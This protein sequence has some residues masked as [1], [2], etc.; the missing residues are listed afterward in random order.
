MRTY[1]ARLSELTEASQDVPHIESPVMLTTVIDF[2]C[3][4][5]FPEIP[6]LVDEGFEAQRDSQ[7]SILG[8]LITN[9]PRTAC[10]RVSGTPL[11]Y[12]LDDRTNIRILHCYTGAA[13]RCLRF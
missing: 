9:S 6:R 13:N 8:Q 4:I 10:S 5:L 3:A 2:R 1:P 7:I 11:R 12:S